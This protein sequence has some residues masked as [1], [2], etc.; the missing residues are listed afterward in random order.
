[1][2]RTQAYVG[3]RGWA[4]LTLAGGA[5]LA[6]PFLRPA[7]IDSARLASGPATS[8]LAAWSPIPSELDGFESSSNLLPGRIVSGTLPTTVSRL[9]D[10]TTS[11][12]P[13]L[14]KWVTQQSPLDELI[15][16][17]KSPAPQPDSYVERPTAE[18][19]PLRTWRGGR[20][21]DGKAPQDYAASSE[22]ESSLAI[23][24]HRDSPWDIAESAAPTLADRQLADPTDNR[25][26]SW[27]DPKW[28]DQTLGHL[29]QE[30][31]QIDRASNP[32]RESDQRPRF[33]GDDHRQAVEV[34]QRT[35]A[36][37]L[38]QASVVTSHAPVIGATLSRT[39]VSAQHSS[40]PSNRT[41]GQRQ[42]GSAALSRPHAPQPAEVDEKR[43]VLQPGLRKG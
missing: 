21:S 34:Q 7:Q 31:A 14:P 25:I 10:W 27:T 15:S 39:P 9:D 17:A 23:S 6:S 38:P 1:M 33:A 3:P 36:A 5:A 2:N 11:E 35:V 42:P 28:P 37:S 16:R 12:I 13:L 8:E 24:S 20:L 4:V 29:P 19:Q 30:L 41:S 40:P 43:F 32:I 26:S 18:L 22:Q